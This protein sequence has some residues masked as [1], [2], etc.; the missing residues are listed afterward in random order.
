MIALHILEQRL[1]AHLR[2]GPE[3]PRE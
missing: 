2:N 1:L 3:F